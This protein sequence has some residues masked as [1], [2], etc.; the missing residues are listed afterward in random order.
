MVNIHHH[1][2]GPAGSRLTTPKVFKKVAF[3][4]LGHDPQYCRDLN[5]PNYCGPMFAV[6]YLKS[7]LPQ[8]DTDSSIRLILLLGSIEN[9]SQV[10]LLSKPP[11]GKPGGPK[12]Y[13]AIPQRSQ[14][15]RHCSYKL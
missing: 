14:V 11:P 13:A 1:A 7:N 12:Q 8:N 4:I 5:T 2:H 6:R 3:W 10:E 15:L 9:E